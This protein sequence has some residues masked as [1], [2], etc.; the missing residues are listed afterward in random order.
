MLNKKLII[1]L[2]IISCGSSLPAMNYF[3]WAKKKLTPRSLFSLV[4][5]HENYGF[6]GNQITPR[7]SFFNYARTPLSRFYQRDTLLSKT[8][9]TIGTALGLGIY[10]HAYAVD[11]RPLGCEPVTG[12]NY[13]WHPLIPEDIPITLD[14]FIKYLESLDNK[15]FADEATRNNDIQTQYESLIGNNFKELLTGNHRQKFLL[16][17]K[18][19]IQKSNE[20]NLLQKIALHLEDLL[21]DYEGHCVIDNAFIPSDYQ[22]VTYFLPYLFDNLALCAQTEKLMYLIRESYYFFGQL[23]HTYKSMGYSPDIHQLLQS[24]P[25]RLKEQWNSVHTKPYAYLLLQNAISLEPSLLDFFLQNIDY[26]TH[27]KVIKSLNKLAPCNIHL[28]NNLINHT[29]NDQIID[30]PLLMKLLAY[31]SSCPNDNA[32]LNRLPKT[33]TVKHLNQN[34]HMVNSLIVPNYIDNTELTRMVN[35]IIAQ[36]NTL[37]EN[38]YTFIHGQ[39]SSYLLAEHLYTFLKQQH[40]NDNP[41]FLYLHVNKEVNDKKTEKKLR[42]YLLANGRNNDEDRQRI[43]FVNYALFANDT[44]SGSNSAH[45]IIQNHNVGA[46]SISFEEIFKNNNIEHLYFKYQSRLRQLYNEYKSLNQYGTCILIAVPKSTIHKH[47][48]TAVSGGGKRAVDIKGH[49]YTYDIR[50]ILK[51]IEESPELIKDTDQLEF[52]IP[53][54]TDKNGGLNPESGIKIFP[55]SAA[56]PSALDAW[57]AQVHA[58]FDEI[59]KDIQ[60]NAQ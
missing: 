32:L 17:L 60:S 47:L 53:M 6:K 41:E 35:A 46:I 2:L 58:L 9:F 42:K 36:E 56:N 24:L 59:Q 21:S 8:F 14:N 10:K 3:H 49:G 52:C 55:F 28:K 51:T 20:K 50:L 33:M 45:Y 1:L 12:S 16:F 31:S 22:S 30:F 54:T 13:A 18:Y 39:R 7:R 27:F 40:S 34:K 26:T 11:E 15:S 4:Y 57:Y 48:Y 29:E 5:K 43:L 44:N 19:F 38:Y 25:R 23:S 37:K